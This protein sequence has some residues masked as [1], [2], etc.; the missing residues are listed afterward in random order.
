MPYVSIQTEKINV[1][2]SRRATQAQQPLPSSDDELR[3]CAMQTVHCAAAGP[4][5]MAKIEI[6]N[7]ELRSDT[8]IVRLSKRLSDVPDP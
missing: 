6:T 2:G 7:L 3:R 4:S 8:T 5:E 1:A